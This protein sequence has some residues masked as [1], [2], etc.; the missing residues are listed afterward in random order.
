MPF[1]LNCWGFYI[2]FGSR[3]RHWNEGPC[4]ICGLCCNVCK[5]V[6]KILLLIVLFPLVYSRCSSVISSNPSQSHLAPRVMLRT[7]LRGNCQS[8]VSGFPVHLAVS[9]AWGN[10]ASLS[11]PQCQSWQWPLQSYRSHAFAEL[12]TPWCLRS[13][14][15]FHDF[16][17]T[18]QWWILVFVVWSRD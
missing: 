9:R 12:C 2:D 5:K 6:G 14:L 17:D 10:T 15:L 16:L 8:T 18:K 1:P 13:K 3:V 11:S 4:F 7:V